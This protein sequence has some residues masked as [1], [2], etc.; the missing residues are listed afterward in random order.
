MESGFR[1]RSP[2]SP[3]HSWALRRHHSWFEDTFLSARMCPRNSGESV[4]QSPAISKTLGRDPVWFK[5]MLCP[6][7]LPPWR[8][9]GN[10]SQKAGCEGGRSCGRE[11]AG[12][13]HTATPPALGIAVVR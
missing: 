1:A 13:R 10:Y 5:A 2:R 6:Q 11:G 9:L 12:D 3:P 7:H 4:R 8:A